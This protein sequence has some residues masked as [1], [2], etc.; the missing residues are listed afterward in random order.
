MHVLRHRKIRRWHWKLCLYQLSFWA[1]PLNHWSFV[2]HGLCCRT[3]RCLNWARDVIVHRD[4]WRWEVFSGR[5]KWVLIVSCRQIRAVDRLW[6]MQHVRRRVIL[7][8]SRSV[9][10]NR[11]V[12]GGQ[13]LVGRSVEL[14]VLPSWQIRSFN[15]LKRLRLL[16]CRLVLRHCRTF[17]GNGVVCCW[18]IFECRI[19]ELLVLWNGELRCWPRELRL[20]W[21]FG[22]SLPLFYGR[23]I[24]HQ[25]CR[26]AIWCFHWSHDV[27]V[28]RDLWRW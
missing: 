9:C 15:G 19:V 12:R 8:H 3:V 26:R 6:R 20:Q 16:Q 21:V 7:R 28:H 5:I 17:C 1:L 4:M 18:K 24:V 23:N 22:R 2:V 11:V 14:L 25:L 13:V 10:G 27:I